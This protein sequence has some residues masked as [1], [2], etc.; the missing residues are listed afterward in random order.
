MILQAIFKDSRSLHKL[1]TILVGIGVLVWLPYF[2]LRIIGKNPEILLYLP[3]HLLGVIAGGRMR[4]AANK[5]LG[6]FK[7]KQKSYAF[8]ARLLMVA[9]ILVWLPYYGLQ[10]AGRTVTVQP[11]LIVHLSSLFLGAAVMGAGG[12]VQYIQKKRSEERNE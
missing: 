10:L 5:K 8:V 7:K 9:S 11:Y 12:M 2:M 6:R 4:N 3:F 1:G